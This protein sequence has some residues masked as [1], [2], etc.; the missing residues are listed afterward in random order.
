MREGDILYAL[1]RKP[2]ESKKQLEKS[3][4][5]GGNFLLSI[6]RDQELFF[7]PWRSE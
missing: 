6:R 3:L 2:L 5:Q 4:L 7:I 1:N